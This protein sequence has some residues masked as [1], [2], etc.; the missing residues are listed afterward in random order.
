MQI[1]DT[2]KKISSLLYLKIYLIRIFQNLFFSTLSLEK[3]GII[4]GGNKFKD[5]DVSND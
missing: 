4:A 5:L 3:N 1:Q 2:D